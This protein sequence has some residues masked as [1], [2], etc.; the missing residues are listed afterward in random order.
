MQGPP[1]GAADPCCRA[2]RER[3]PEVPSQETPVRPR[4]EHLP[5]RCRGL[6]GKDKSCDSPVSATLTSCPQP[7]PRPPQLARQPW[8]RARPYGNGPRDAPTPWPTPPA[9]SSSFTSQRPSRVPRE[10]APHPPL[11]LPL[12][13][14]GALLPTDPRV[15]PPDPAPEIIAG[16]QAA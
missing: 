14:P 3:S 2:A 12:G 5:R 7:C 13:D 9:V 4:E 1:G 6:G 10:P 16:P 11:R 8:T 15:R